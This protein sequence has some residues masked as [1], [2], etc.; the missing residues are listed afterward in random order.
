MSFILRPSLEDSLS[1]LWGAGDR[2]QPPLY[3]LPIEFDTSK[4]KVLIDIRRK[5]HM[6]PGG[7]LLAMGRITAVEVSSPEDYRRRIAL[8]G[9]HLGYGPERSPQLVIDLARAEEQRI[10][11]CRVSAVPPTRQDVS[12][13]E[14]RLAHI[15]FA[16]FEANRAGVLTADFAAE[17]RMPDV[18]LLAEAAGEVLVK[19]FVG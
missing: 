4:V 2:L 13:L 11:D 7:Y 1:M 8:T 17:S 19:G 18:R 5:W 15:P 6:N 16:L 14:H 12:P 10:V 9:Q 3:E